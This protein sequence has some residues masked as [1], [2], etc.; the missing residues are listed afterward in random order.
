M[1]SMTRFDGNFLLDK[2]LTPEHK[3]ALQAF[4]DRP[5]M[6]WNT[7]LLNDYPD[8]PPE[9]IGLPIGTYGCYFIGGLES[10][11]DR[12]WVE[13]SAVICPTPPAVPPYLVRWSPDEEEKWA[14]QDGKKF[15]IDWLRFQLNDFLIPWGYVLNGRVT[16]E[17]E[18]PGDVGTIVVQDNAITVIREVKEH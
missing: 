9:A 15:Y 4:A 5:H 7:Q 18:L 16:W 8:L 14:Q 1:K 17:G 13:H 10:D 12:S 6:K 3:D 2:P 11:D